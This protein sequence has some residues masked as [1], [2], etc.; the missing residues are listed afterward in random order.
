MYP[1]A[2]GQGAGS[3]VGAGVDATRLSAEL[4]SK[5]QAVENSPGARFRPR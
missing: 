3:G 2:A 5:R 4:P 1:R